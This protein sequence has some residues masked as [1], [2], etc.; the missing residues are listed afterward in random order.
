MAHYTCAYTGE[1]SLNEMA[2]KTIHTPALLHPKRTV[3]TLHDRS[4]RDQ[5]YTYHIRVGSSTDDSDV[6]MEMSESI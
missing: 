1:L 4:A 5:P 6:G 2:E 3:Q